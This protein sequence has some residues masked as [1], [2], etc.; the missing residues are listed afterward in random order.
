MCSVQSN[1]NLDKIKSIFYVCPVSNGEKSDCCYYY[2]PYTGLARYV[3]SQLLVRPVTLNHKKIRSD[4]NDTFVNV[5]HQ[6]NHKG[7][8]HTCWMPIRIKRMT[9]APNKNMY[10][11]SIPPFMASLN[12]GR[13][14]Q[15]KLGRTSATLNVCCSLNLCGITVQCVLTSTFLVRP[16]IGGQAPQSS[17]SVSQ[18]VGQSFCHN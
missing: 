13:I 11:A 5:Q 18:T 6:Y 7:H 8:S 4:S 9:G 2:C 17:M 1:Q 3:C 16:P 10:P 14:I 12:R 15:K